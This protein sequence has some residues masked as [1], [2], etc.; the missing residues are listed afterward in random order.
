MMHRLNVR[1]YVCKDQKTDKNTGGCCEKKK[2]ITTKSS[3]NV[4]TTIL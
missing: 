2:V 3:Y 1:V 4:Q